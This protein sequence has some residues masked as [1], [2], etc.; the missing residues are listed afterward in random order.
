MTRRIETT[1]NVGFRICDLLTEIT[2][3]KDLLLM[4][5][6]VKRLSKN[7]YSVSNISFAW[8]CRIENVADKYWY[9]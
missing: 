6:D 5:Y 2:L 7:C 8:L 4:G 3:V 9:F 1:Y